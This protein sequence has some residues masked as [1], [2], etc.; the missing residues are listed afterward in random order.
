MRG[1]LLPLCALAALVS[2]GCSASPFG[3]LPEVAD[4]EAL[5][6]DAKALQAA[7]SAAAIDPREWPASIA[8]LHP[9]TVETTLTRVLITVDAK[10]GVGAHGYL[11]ALQGVPDVG[12]WKLHATANAELF[13]FDWQP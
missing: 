6:R 5:V 3:A 11:V 8:A 7:H 12:H 10:P 13:A 2:G 9:M 1:L 4:P